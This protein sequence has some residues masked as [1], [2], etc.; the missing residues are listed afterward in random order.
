MSFYL[1]RWL[2]GPVFLLEGLAVTLSLGC[3]QPG[4]VLRYEA[5]FID[6]ADEKEW[7]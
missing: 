1:A 2:G 6:L 5:W 3:W 4:W 7:P